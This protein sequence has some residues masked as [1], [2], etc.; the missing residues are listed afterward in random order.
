MRIQLAALV[1]IGFATLTLRAHANPISVDAATL[2]IFRT[3]TGQNDV[4]VSQGDN[5][6]FGADINGGSLGTSIAGIFTPT[7]AVNPTF[8][9]SFAV[10]G[11]LDTNQNFCDRTTPFSIAKTN[12][13]WQVEFENGPNTVTL[14]LPPV[15]VIPANPVLP[16]FSVTIT[17]MGTT[18]TISWTL[19]GNT[20]P[21]AYRISIFDK[22]QVTANGVSNQIIYTTN[23]NPSVTSFT[24]PVA[25]G[26][27]VGGNY[28]IELQ[29][30][31]TRDG[32]P[33]VENANNENADIL[34]RSSAYFDFG[35][36]ANGSPP[37]I[38][39]PT[40]AANGVYH[41]NVGSV[42]PN[43]V[44]FI[45]PAVAVGYI[46]DI[47]QG[48]PNFASVLLPDVGGGR[49]D[50]SYLINDSEFDTM[51]AAGIQYFFPASGID[52]FTV[53]GIDPAAGIDPTNALA[54]ITGLT[55]VS[56]GSFTGTMTPITEVVAT[57]EPGSIA[58]LASGLLG[59]VLFRRGRRSASAS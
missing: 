1:A 51:L 7:G 5:F 48:D 34:T 58:L 40:I 17:E 18:P 50:L 4:G 31:N 11:P 9:T 21:N 55:F 14:P 41:F 37:V 29:V 30:I 8:T 44:T 23:L 39:L 22:S 38:Q 46:Y 45:D 2:N 25:A 16:P 3:E 26:L 49:F 57:P 12:G 27:A 36:P 20:N 6:Q 52:E 42:G 59:L 35:L 43:S 32:Q 47:G 15:S 54:F 28:A 19:Q 24:V 13:S 10:C 33:L 56:D 53:T